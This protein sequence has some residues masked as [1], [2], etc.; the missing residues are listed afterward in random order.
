MPPRYAKT[1]ERMSGTIRGLRS[2][3]LKIKCTTTLPQVCAT[4]LSP[5]QGLLP[6]CILTQGLR[7]GLQS[8]AASRLIDCVRDRLGEDVTDITTRQRA[9]RGIPE[10]ER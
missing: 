10:M 2:L 8:V 5:F 3:V 4:F 7:P 9:I 1:S 6:D